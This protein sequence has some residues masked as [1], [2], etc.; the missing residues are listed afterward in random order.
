MHRIVIGISILIVCMVGM[1]SGTRADDLVEGKM[2][3]QDNC[4]VCHGLIKSETAHNIPAPTSRQAIRA[5]WVLRSGAV[6]TDASGSTHGRLAPAY[7][8]PLRGV[9]GRPA[10]S[11]ESFMYSPA[12][13]NA[14]QGVV[15]NRKALDAWITDSQARA[16]GARM[17]YKQ[18]DPEIRRKII[19]YLEANSRD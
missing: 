11:M 18:P 1:T 4:G 2:L 12:F 19:M 17:Y 5:A 16:P 14:L 15:W 13:K 10:G 8:P 9:Y 3:Y 6:S 7:G